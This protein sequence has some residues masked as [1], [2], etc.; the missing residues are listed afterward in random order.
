GDILAAVLCPFAGGCRQALWL[1]PVLAPA[2][3]VPSLAPEKVP[4]ESVQGEDPLD[5]PRS[6]ALR[7]SLSG[8]LD[9]RLRNFPRRPA[10]LCIRMLWLLHPTGRL[11][12]GKWGPRKNPAQRSLWG[13]EPQRNG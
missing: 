10:A 9:P 8:V 6:V 7:P 13:E 12:Q 4:K 3:E 1:F 2:G 11:A 5:T